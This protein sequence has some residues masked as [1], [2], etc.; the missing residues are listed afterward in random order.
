M[1]A[2]IN[3]WG[4]ASSEEQQSLVTAAFQYHELKLFL[5]VS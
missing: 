4:A 1:R 2:P 5:A 3:T